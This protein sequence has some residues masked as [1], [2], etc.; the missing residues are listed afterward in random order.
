[1]NDFKVIAKNIWLTLLWTWCIC[2]TAEKS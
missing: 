1:V 2:N